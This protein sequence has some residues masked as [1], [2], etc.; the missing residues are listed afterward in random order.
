MGGEGGPHE[1]DVGAARQQGAEDAQEEVPR[2][3][4]LVYLPSEEGERAYEPVMATVAT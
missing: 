3:V 4:P 2:E 1:S